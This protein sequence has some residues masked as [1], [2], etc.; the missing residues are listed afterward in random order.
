MIKFKTLSINILIFFTLFLIA[1]V[2]FGYWFKENNFGIYMRKERNINWLTESSFNNKKYQFNYKRN[3]W[4]FRAEN[5]HPK[6]FN[7]VFEGGSTG[8]QRYTPDKMTIVGILNKLINEKKLNFKILNASTDG[9]STAGYVND[10]KYWFPKIKNFEPGVFIF[11]IGIN[12]RHRDDNVKHYDLKISSKKIDQVKDYIKNN[13]FVIEKY[14]LFKN[15]Y[16]PTNTLSYDFNRNDLYKND[17]KYVSYSDALKVHEPSKIDL[18]KIQAFQMRLE[19][20]REIIIKENIT[21]IF[22]TQ[23]AYNGLE[24][25]L[26]FFI[27]EELKR[28][29]K[30]NN[31]YIIPLDEIIEMKVNDFYDEIHTTPQ[32]SK[33]IAETL[34][35]YIENYLTNEL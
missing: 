33:R 19:N 35:P 26:L 12:D 29:S 23:I 22:I 10:F 2:I 4:G 32:G 14:K 1:E 16:F 8:N 15:I 7:I 31:F 18:E 5:I 20:L 34:W 6:N 30:I 24:D 11:Y 17:F 13:S 28:F 3:M 27:N 21:P 25:P 9:K